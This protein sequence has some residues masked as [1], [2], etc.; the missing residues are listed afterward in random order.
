MIPR[1]LSILSTAA[2]AAILLAGCIHQTPS[3]SLPSYSASKISS[4]AIAALDTNHDSFLDGKE[5][6]KAPG[7]KAALERIDADKDSRISVTEIESRINAYEK[8]R[9]GL[10]NET[11]R[12]TLNGAPLADAHVVFSPEPFFANAI[13][14]GEGQTRENGSTA[15]RI[16]GNHVPGLTCGM[17]QVSVSKKDASGKELI[18]AKYNTQTILGYEFPPAE[19][20]SDSSRTFAL[21]SR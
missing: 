9:V 8:A 20:S 21:S 5:L 15:A 12:F 7:L 10:R 17:Y 11:Y 14:P 18:P 16:E 2:L 1:W 6:E 3:I 4:E 19:F 13:K